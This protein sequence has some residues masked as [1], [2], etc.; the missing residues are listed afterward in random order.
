VIHSPYNFR[1][2][3]LL[4]SVTLLS[5]DIDEHQMVTPCYYW[6]SSV[7]FEGPKDLHLQTNFSSLKIIEGY[8][9]TT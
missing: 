2:G 9:G 1:C 6:I 8:P 7:G 3:M 5:S 4:S